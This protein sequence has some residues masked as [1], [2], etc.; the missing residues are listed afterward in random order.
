MSDL[1]TDSATSAPVAEHPIR[2]L[3]L[4]DDPTNLLLRAVILRQHGYACV[5]AASV[6]EAMQSFEDIDVA[7]L[8]YHLGAGQFGTDVAVDLRKVRPE[9]PII[10]LSATLEHRFGG[11]E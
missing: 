7:V 9:V 10:I 5:T 11:V 8:D 2:V 4:D 6:E 3:L 1:P